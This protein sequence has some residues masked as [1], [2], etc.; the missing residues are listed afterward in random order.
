[1]SNAGTSAARGE[2]A[3]TAACAALVR[4][5]FVI[6]ARRLRTPLGEIDI[7]AATGGLLVFVEVKS[8]PSLAG[9]AAALGPRQ[10][11]RLMAAAEYALAG[12]PDW[13]RAAMRFDVILVDRAGRMRR[14]RDAFRLGG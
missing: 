7:V 8:R 3:E 11:G 6:L 12:Q 4:D 14:I 9:A 1:M 10:Q 5:G 13:A 2:A